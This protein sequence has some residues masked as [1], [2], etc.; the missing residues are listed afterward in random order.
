VQARKVLL[1]SMDEDVSNKVEELMRVSGVGLSLLASPSL[2]T[3]FG[4]EGKDIRR[5]RGGR[6]S[7]EVLEEMMYSLGSLH[8]ALLPCSCPLPQKPLIQYLN[9][10]LLLLRE[11]FLWIIVRGVPRA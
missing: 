11:I 7:M 2:T 10:F 3:V 6:P 5:R 9:L 8:L 1:D 4:G